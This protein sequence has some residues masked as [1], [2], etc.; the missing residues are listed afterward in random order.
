LNP[1]LRVLEALE[2]AYQGTFADGYEATF[3][4]AVA[5]SD[6]YEQL[7]LLGYEELLQE[8]KH[9]LLFNWRLAQRSLLDSFTHSNIFRILLESETIIKHLYSIRNDQYRYTVLEIKSALLD[10]ILDAVS[11]ELDEFLEEFEY[12]DFEEDKKSAFLNCNP[13]ETIIAVI[14]LCSMLR[15]LDADLHDTPIEILIPERDDV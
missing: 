1:K 9:M 14:E 11:Y 15:E 13:T 7:D 3:T 8:S 10:R 6:A 2:Q 12:S 4:E 5:L